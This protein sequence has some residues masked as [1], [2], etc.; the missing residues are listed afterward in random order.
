MTDSINERIRKYRISKKLKQSE[1]GEKLGLKCSTYSQMERKGTISVEMALKIAKILEI[2]PALIIYGNE[3]EDKL[4]FTP[5]KPQKVTANAPMTVID[6]I[7]GEVKKKETESEFPFELSNTEKNI[8]SIYHNLSKP[9][10]R[11]IREF[12]DE[13]RKKG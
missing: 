6:G 2:D 9:K 3:T 8:I 13:I 12:I 11:Q 1:L 7:Y 5:I 4:E 10:Q